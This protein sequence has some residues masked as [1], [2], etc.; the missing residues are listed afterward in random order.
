MRILIAE[1]DATSRKFL[2][3]L[4]SKYGECD[5]VVDGIE[6]VEAFEIAHDIG[7]P[8]DLI[9]LDIMMP[10]ID[11][12]KALKAIRDFER[13]KGIEKERRC[14]VIFTSALDETEAGFDALRTGNEI[15]ITKP[16]DIDKF[17]DVL[18][19]LLGI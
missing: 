14:K 7:Q 4:L 8:Y 6:V 2:F 13:N 5:M 16:I 19:Q 17:M 12:I 3:K 18:N 9:C 10:K 15:Y 11:G 1:D